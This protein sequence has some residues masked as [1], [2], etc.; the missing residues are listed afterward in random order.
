MKAQAVGYW[1]CTVAIG[2]SFF[3]GRGRRPVAPIVCTRGY[4][5]PGLSGLLHDHPGLLESLGRSRD[6]AARLPPAKGVGLRRHDFRPDRSFGLARR[7]GRRRVSHT[8]TLVLAVLVV[9]SWAL[10]PEGRKLK[11]D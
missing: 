5:P 9:A 10:R 2:L 6:S 3:V 7:L 11:R 1:I 4:D 8:H